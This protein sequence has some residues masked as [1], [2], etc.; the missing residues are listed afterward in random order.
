MVCLG[1]ICR[2]PT[3]E[4]VLR[5]KLAKAG[6]ERHVEVGSAGTH[7]E[8]GGAPDARA[9]AAAARRGY[10]LS[11]IRSRRLV[12]KDFERFDLLLAMD[13]D[14]LEHLSN[15]CPPGEHH[16]LGLLLEMGAPSLGL[17]EVPDPYYGAPAGFERVLDLIEPACEG[18]VV[19]LQRRLLGTS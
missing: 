14:N 17:R 12:V 11:R 7:G 2:S 8:R 6:L 4:A 1:N 3:A 9:V 5:T 15:Q 16:R 13:L 18:L 19:S 10:D